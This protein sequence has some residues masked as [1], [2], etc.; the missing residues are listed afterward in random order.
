VNRK[1][2]V[3]I[4]II[5]LGLVNYSFF[6]SGCVSIGNTIEIKCGEGSEIYL[7]VVNIFILIGTYIYL[8]GAN[9]K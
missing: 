8:K 5:L 7:V 2:T 1:Y 6:D 3:L 9:K 4:S